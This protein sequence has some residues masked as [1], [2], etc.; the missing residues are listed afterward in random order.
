MSTTIVVGIDGSIASAAALDW[1]AW[2]AARNGYGLD[3]CAVIEPRWGA[4]R[5]AHLAE[6]SDRALDL[7]RVRATSAVPPVEVTARSLSGSAPVQ[8]VAESGHAAALVV[9]TDKTST[10][11][12]L[13]HGTTPLKLGAATRCPLAVVPSDWATGT[14]PVVVG[15]DHE[16]DAK[17]VAFAAKAAS[18]LGLPLVM[19]H[20]WESPTFLEGEYFDS[21]EVVAAEGEAAQEVLDAA[22]QQVTA[23][24]PELVVDSRLAHR[25]ASVAMTVAAKGATMVVVGSHR[26]NAVADLVLGSVGHDL[27]MN[28]PSVVVIVPPDDDLPQVTADLLNEYL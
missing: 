25:T 21:S 27:L 19:V 1:A 6:A 18:L 22:T 15:V 13:V 5:A 14:G 12:R 7:A 28:M 17:A 4:D 10:V 23:Q 24:F 20:A 16:T 8:L 2:W 9:G 11:A 26:R 3:L